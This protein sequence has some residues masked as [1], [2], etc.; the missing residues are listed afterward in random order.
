MASCRRT[1]DQTARP[2]ADRREDG[3]ARPCAGDR[4]GFLVDE[5]RRRDVAR[6]RYFTSSIAGS[7]AHRRTSSI[8]NR[9]SP[10]TVAVM[11]SA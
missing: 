2:R 4:E 8:S 3:F 6:I 9:V 1:R 5:A 11:N 10:L 7:H